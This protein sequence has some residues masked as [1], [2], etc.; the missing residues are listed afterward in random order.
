MIKLYV[1]RFHPYRKTDMIAYDSITQLFNLVKMKDKNTFYFEKQ[2]N[3]EVT[4]LGWFF[5]PYVQQ[6]MDNKFKIRNNV[7]QDY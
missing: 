3:A 2:N 4:H 5:W 1:G 7:L 6:K